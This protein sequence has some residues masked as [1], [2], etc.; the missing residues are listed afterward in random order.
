MGHTLARNQKAS[1]VSTYVVEV[2]VEGPG[3]MEDW[4]GG[5]QFLCKA[6]SE[7]SAHEAHDHSGGQAPWRQTRRIGIAAAWESE[8]E[9]VLGVWL[10]PG[11]NLLERGV[12]L[13]R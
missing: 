13:E 1:A 9:R 5:V 11:R 7:G 8:V 4:T 2:E 10:A 6:C 3:W 12:G